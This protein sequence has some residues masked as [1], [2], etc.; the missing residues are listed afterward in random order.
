MPA[1]AIQ[2]GK[3]TGHARWF[4][5]PDVGPYTTKS[6]FNG[7]PI[8]LRG[9][10]AYA[11]HTRPGKSP[12]PHPPHNNTKHIIKQKAGTFYME[13]KVVAMIGDD[14]DCG[15]AVAKGSSSAFIR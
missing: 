7:R 6:Y 2:G 14:M 5:V 11:V 13:G 1:I 15:D 3:S 12:D 8:Q 4:P 9:V 10:T